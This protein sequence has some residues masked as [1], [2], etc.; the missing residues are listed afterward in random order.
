MSQKSP[1]RHICILDIQLEFRKK[2]NN[3]NIKG[4]VSRTV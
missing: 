2:T 1:Y 4:K 3:Y